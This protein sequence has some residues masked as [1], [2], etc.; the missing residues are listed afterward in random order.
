[1]LA[2]TSTFCFEIRCS[3]DPGDT[4]ILAKS[5]HFLLSLQEQ[6]TKFQAPTAPTQ[7][8]EEQ[9]VAC[10]LLKKQCLGDV[11]LHMHCGCLLDIGAQRLAACQSHGSKRKPT[12]PISQDIKN[13][14]FHDYIL[15]EPN[16]L[17]RTL[18]ACQMTNKQQSTFS[19]GRVQPA[20]LLPFCTGIKQ[21]LKD[22][23]LLILVFIPFSDHSEVMRHWVRQFCASASRRLRGLVLSWTL[24]PPERWGAIMVGCEE[25]Q[26]LKHYFSR[27]RTRD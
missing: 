5:L 23:E 4:W 21:V 6:I 3:L 18:P 14:I 24:Q 2:S 25:L 12:S 15:R 26:V 13:M 7:T 17:T 19:Q 8:I 9:N 22:I 27:S 1:M 20:T 11:T 10:K 16:R